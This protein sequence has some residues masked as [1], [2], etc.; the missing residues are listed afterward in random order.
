MTPSLI[1]DNPK[2]WIFSIQIS[3]LVVIIPSC[4]SWILT[5][6]QAAKWFKP[7]PRIV[8]H[9]HYWSP[10]KSTRM[11][12][13]HPSSIT[14][15]GSMISEDSRSSPSCASA[16]FL[17]RKEVAR[18]SSPKMLPVFIFYTLNVQN[19][20]P[21]ASLRCATT[22]PSFPSTLSSHCFKFYQVLMLITHLNMS[23]APSR[24]TLFPNFKKL[25]KEVVC[26]SIPGPTSRNKKL[27]RWP[28]AFR[29]PKH[30]QISRSLWHGVWKM[31]V[32]AQTT[33]PNP[34]GILQVII[35]V[36]GRHSCW[37]APPEDRKTCKSFGTSTKR[38]LLCFALDGHVHNYEQSCP[39]YK[40][41][42]HYC[43]ICYW[44]CGIYTCL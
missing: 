15:T 29:V 33:V 22:S 2:K 35:M 42:I 25:M 44:I 27:A 40:I 38:T 4:I 41:E 23:V 34:L 13:P 1:S 9:C 20:P 39:M 24:I 26:G 36:G 19:P 16:S 11:E 37:W 31:S 21:Y 28:C 17:S 43:L 7:R 14:T 32:A 18:E 3:L 8:P 10:L 6:K 12:D 5:L 30:K